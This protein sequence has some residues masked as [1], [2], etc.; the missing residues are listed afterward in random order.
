VFSRFVGRAAEVRALVTALDQSVQGS[1]QMRVVIGEAGVGK[2]TLVRQLLPEARL[3]GAVMVTGRAL[4]TE[5]RAPYGP[6]TEMLRSIHELGIAPE[7][8]WPMLERLLPALH[9]GTAPMTPMPLPALDSAQGHH[10]LQELFTFLRMVSE[11]RPIGLVLEDMHWADSA[12]WD[13]LE[14]VLAQLTTERV[15]LALTVRSEEAAYGVVRERRQRLSRDERSRERHI[16]RLTVAEVTEWLRGALHRDELGDD[17]VQFVLRHTEGNPF[18]VM[19]LMR[20]LVEE[21]VFAH[22]G[23]AW[24]WT[25]PSALTLPAGMSDLVGRRL[26]RLPHEAMRILVTAAA[27]G[28]VFTVQLLADAAG[29][30]IDAVLDAVDS[31]L[32]ASV[33]EP[34]HAESDDTYQFAHALLVDAVLRSVSPARRRLTYERVAD[35]LAARTPDAIDQIASHYARSGN[36]GKAYAWCTR[37]A[38]RAMS[39]Y[40]LDVATDFLQLALEHAGTDD[41]RFAIHDELARA[42]QLSG[43]WVEVERSCDEMLAMPG[44][45]E[46]PARSLPVQQRRLQARVR[47]GQ[48]ARDMEQE[49]R[50]LLTTA[51][52]VGTLGDVVRTRSLLVQTLSRRGRS[53]EAVAIAAESLRL[54]EESDDTALTAEAMHRLADTLLAARPAEAI[55]L[56][57][58]LIDHAR[59]HADPVLE[60][61]AFLVLGVARMR[62]RDDR[63][64]ATAFRSA[65]ELGLEAQ[66]LDVAAGA[67]MNLGVIELRGGDFAAAHTAFNE[68]LRLY[69]TLRNN[70]NRLAALY[71]LANL[72]R[73]RGDATASASLYRETS[74]LADHLNA[75]DIAIGAQAGAGWAA[76]RLHDV[77]TA[78]SALTAAQRMLGARHDWWFQGRELLES[79]T[80]RLA[81]RS[82]DFDG[83]QARF[84]LAVE[85]L[86]QT[87]VYAA[88]WMI[89]DCA[90]ELAEHDPAVWTIVGRFAEHSTVQQFAPLSARFTALRDM[91]DRLLTGRLREGAGSAA[92]AADALSEDAAAD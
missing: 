6:W 56:L 19:Q 73:E 34:A 88:A 18:L 92:P 49:C 29:V 15:F 23:T 38:S 40:A 51:E 65:L 71:N 47:L 58:R 83:A 68:A 3:R 79:L 22:N 57:N 25:L 81:T 13:A 60:A 91:S 61:R 35:L 78:R 52:S 46:S 41:E 59:T 66:A 26:N 8:H 24:S 44:V 16:E 45:I 87:D 64:G 89:A 67:S 53:D 86:E 37:A 42:A 27:I 82:G 11:T 72:E 84:R 90:A 32:A 5:S 80:I 20:T 30:T 31:G 39:L 74:V 10:L 62:T 85:R 1:P 70:T 17:L 69:T 43:R 54:A 21:N 7:R 4:E 36:S 2:S 76:L 33:L 28:R 77:A 9:T 48:G 14:Y 75:K 50:D 12:S 55:E 63:G